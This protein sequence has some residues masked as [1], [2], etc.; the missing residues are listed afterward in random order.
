MRC[1]RR[2]VVLTG[3]EAVE[4]APSGKARALLAR[5]A[6]AWALWLPLRGRGQT[7]G[8]TTLLYAAAE[9][10][11]PPTSPPPGTSPTAPA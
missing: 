3:A 2:A 5:L 6:P 8:M 1:R 11:R 7:L 10:P 4:L 9:P